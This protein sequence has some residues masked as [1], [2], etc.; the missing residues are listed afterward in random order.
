MGASGVKNFQSD[1]GMDF[2]DEFLENPFP[3]TVVYALLLVTRDY[4]SG[5][6]FEIEPY[7]QHDQC[8]AAL[9]AA[10]VVAAARSKPSSDFPKSLQPIIENLVLGLDIRTR[11][12][13][14]QAVRNVLKKSELR[15]LWAE[16]GEERLNEWEA[17]QKDLLV[18][19]K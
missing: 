2:E 15:S 19:L 10:E 9:A 6:H 1:E 13:A 7:E 12:L 5:K 4:I 16:T 3:N 11:K 8:C 17:V 14:R 18:R